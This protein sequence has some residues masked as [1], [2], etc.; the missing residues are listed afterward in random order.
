MK[1]RGEGWWDGTAVTG[2]ISRWRVRD[3][4]MNIW[5]GGREQERKMLGFCNDSSGINTWSHW[6]Y[7]LVERWEQRRQTAEKERFVFVNVPF[8]VNCRLLLIWSCRGC[9]TPVVIVWGEGIHSVQVTKWHTH[10]HTLF[11]HTLTRKG[12]LESPN[13][14]S[15]SG[16]ESKRWKKIRHWE[17]RQ[18]FHVQSWVQKCVQHLRDVL[19]NPVLF[20]FNLHS[21]HYTCV[22]DSNCSHV[23]KSK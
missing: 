12:S 17:K 4:W 23:I 11:I 9:Q 15:D 7:G 3:G 2:N 8:S 5:G 22:I 19:V 18:N 1:E 13:R 6:H 14:H 21:S 10:T 20:L 16:M